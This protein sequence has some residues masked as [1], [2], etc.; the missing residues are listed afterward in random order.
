ME[1][2]SDQQ[3]KPRK[4]RLWYVKERQNL[5]REIESLLKATENRTSRKNKIDRKKSN[6][7]EVSSD[8]QAKPRKRR[9]GYVK[10]RQNLL[11]EIESLLK[12]TV[13]RTPRK[14]KIDRKKSNYMEVSS[15]KQAK[16]HKRWLGYGKERQ[17]LMREIE[18]L[19]KATLNNTMNTNYVKS[20]RDKTQQ[21]ASA[22]CSVV[23]KA[24]HLWKNKWLQQI[25]AKRGQD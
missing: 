1:V 24:H 5:M 6:Y 12:A 25:S 16:P 18:S 7:M 14:N 10:E 2:W 19:L 8:K 11:R 15:D 3:A 13:N 9:L 20:K 21:K 17:N 4:R 23:I 22:W